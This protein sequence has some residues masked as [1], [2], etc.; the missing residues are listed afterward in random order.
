MSKQ[1]KI[2]ITDRFISNR[3]KP[4]EKFETIWDSRV[5][6][7]VLHYQSGG[8]SFWGYSWF[9]PLSKTIL[10]KLGKWNQNTF[11]CADA[12][13]KFIADKSTFIDKGIDP[14]VKKKQDRLLA[15]QKQLRDADKS[16]FQKLIQ[17]YVEAEFP[18]VKGFGN[19][20]GINVNRCGM[21]YLECFDERGARCCS[22]CLCCCL[23]MSQKK[24]L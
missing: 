18:Q 23:M 12:R 24:Q 14:R 5:Q 16:I 20:T 9:G 1:K 8:W 22:R 4:A 7:K 19:C 15:H 10:W 2:V 21:P 3:D 17:K 6:M 11:N 13:A